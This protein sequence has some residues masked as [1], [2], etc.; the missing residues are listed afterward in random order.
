ML[1]AEERRRNSGAYRFV[2]GL[3]RSDAWFAI[4]RLEDQWKR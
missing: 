4:K 2:L 3:W 1:I